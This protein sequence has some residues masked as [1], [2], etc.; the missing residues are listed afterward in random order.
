MDAGPLASGVG[1]RHTGRQPADENAGRGLQHSLGI[2]LIANDE[3]RSGVDE[4][5]RS[6]Q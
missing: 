4:E 2:R 3:S 5:H 6:V 1:H